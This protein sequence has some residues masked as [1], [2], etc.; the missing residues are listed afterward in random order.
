MNNIARKLRADEIEHL[1]IILKK[2]NLKSKT[3]TLDRLRCAIYAR[4]SQ[5]DT[6]DTSLPTQIEY[7]KELIEGCNLLE[8]SLVYQEDNKSGMWDD[9]PEFQAMI[10]SIQNNEID[11]VIVYKWDRFARK[12]SDAQ[13]YYDKV[14]SAGG[15]IITG[16][17]ILLV[18]SSHAL[19]MQ[20]MLWANSEYQAR[21]SAERTIDTL[22]SSSR[23]GKHVS[24]A[25][26]LGYKKEGSGKSSKVVIDDKESLI[27]YQIF[28]KLSSGLSI[29]TVTKQ[30]NTSGLRTRKGSYF[31]KQSVEY[32]A[33]NPIYIGTLVYNKFGAKKKSHRLLQKD[34]EEVVI[35]NAFLP[36]IDKSKFDMV[37]QILESKIT[38]RYIDTGYIY[39]LSGLIKCKSCGLT[40]VGE[41]QTGRSQKAKEILL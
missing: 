18:D 10:K 15:T 17:S 34:Y 21:V 28:D 16:D 35:E 25:L 26:P 14:V 11:V 40:M 13:L 22:L 12:S 4:K 30:L 39:L 24:G 2:K 37:Q 3:R 31:T 23:E 32:I 41:C 6:K 1:Q 29:N 7:C 19:F 9:R 38:Q 20:Q 27:V 5:E 36:I 33:K 8:L